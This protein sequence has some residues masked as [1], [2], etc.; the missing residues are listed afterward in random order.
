MDK[1]KL[2]TA[3]N[4]W[5]IC[6]GPGAALIMTCQRIGWAVD[7]A[8][9][10]VTDGGAILNLLLDPPKVVIQQVF[11]A[12]QRWRWKRVE[13]NLRQLA[14]NGSGRG[15]FM[16]PIWQLLKPSFS[17]KGWT[18][19]HKGCLRSAITVSTNPCDGVRVV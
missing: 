14:R 12:V 11:E 15:P 6:Y 10:L 19:S 8:T 17:D 18:P 2:I 3:K 13:I 7:S 1:S 9:R 16:E 5:A 4:K